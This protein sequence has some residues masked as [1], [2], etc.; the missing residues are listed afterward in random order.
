MTSFKNRGKYNNNG[1][2]YAVRFSNSKE[3]VPSEGD[4]ESIHWTV[5]VLFE[6]E[7]AGG[8]FWHREM[9]FEC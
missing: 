9:D 6:N 7:R 8:I 3:K 1:G 2:K 4:F 5:D